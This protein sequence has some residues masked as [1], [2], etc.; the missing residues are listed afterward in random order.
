MGGKGIESMRAKVGVTS[1]VSV[2][3][4]GHGGGLRDGAEE[5]EEEEEDEVVH[6]AARLLL[7]P[8]FALV[9]K[10]CPCWAG[11]HS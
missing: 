4:W 7:T 8:T 5:E 3:V 1:S 11:V 10:G 2:R 9:A 6:L